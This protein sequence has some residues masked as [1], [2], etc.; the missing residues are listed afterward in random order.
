MKHWTTTAT[1]DGKKIALFVTTSPESVETDLAAGSIGSLID[2]VRSRRFP[3]EVVDNEAALAL[4]A[5]DH[6]ASLRGYTWTG[7]IELVPKYE[8]SVAQSYYGGA[9][10]HGTHTYAVVIHERPED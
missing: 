2:N 1:K 3:N 6:H 5:F 7:R 8:P 4:G 10:I 9:K